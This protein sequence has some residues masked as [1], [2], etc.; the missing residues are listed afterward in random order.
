LPINILYQDPK[1]TAQLK[2]NI[3]DSN[4]FFIKRIN[5]KHILQIKSLD[6]KQAKEL[7]IKCNTK[8]YTYTSKSE[9]LLLKGLNNSHEVKEVLEELRSL[10]ISDIEFQKVIRFST[11]RSKLEKKHYLYL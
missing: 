5:G 2:L 10:N 1:D 11:N 8:F 7:L 9:N 4:N 6:F 3:K